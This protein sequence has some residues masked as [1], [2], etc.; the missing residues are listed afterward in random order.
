MDLQ[1]KVEERLKQIEEIEGEPKEEKVDNLKEF[2]SMLLGSKLVGHVHHFQTEGEG[3]FAKHKALQ[4]FYESANDIAD[5]IIE[6]YQGCTLSIVEFSADTLTYGVGMDSIEYL[7]EL[8]WAIQEGRKIK[9]LA[10][11][12]HIQNEID[13]FIALIDQ[14]TYKLTFL[15]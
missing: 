11:E 8:R 5:T 3:S 12:S 10:D 7:T 6:V 9:V 1:N 14:T 15:K 2:F 13:N 4:E